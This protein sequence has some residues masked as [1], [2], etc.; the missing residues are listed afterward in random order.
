M[1]RWH[2]AT[3]A[4][5]PSV[6]CSADHWAYR[7][8]NILVSQNSARRIKQRLQRGAGDITVDTHAVARFAQFPLTTH[9]RDCPAVALMPQRVFMIVADFQLNIVTAAQRIYRAGQQTVAAAGNMLLFIAITDARV[10]M[11]DNLLVTA[12]VVTQ[13]F[14][15]RLLSQPVTLTEQSPD[16]AGAHFFAVRIGVPLNG[17]AEID[18]QT[19]RQ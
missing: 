11:A 10:E 2:S 3:T 18:L 4:R 8:V 1:W 7:Q 19:T 6:R 12:D 16:I 17:F 9:V 15:H 5:V 14:H 13:Q